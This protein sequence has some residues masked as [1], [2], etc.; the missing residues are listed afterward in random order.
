ML[1]F[2]RV[3][4][5]IIRLEFL[6]TN[7]THMHTHQTELVRFS[8]PLCSIALTFDPNPAL[9]LDKVCSEASFVLLRDFI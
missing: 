3:D 4:F 9:P 6:W 7:F 5:K 2:P 1:L 8:N